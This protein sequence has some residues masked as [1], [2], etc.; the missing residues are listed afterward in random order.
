MSKIVTKNEIR[1]LGVSYFD[2]DLVLGPH[3]QENGRK[4]LQHLLMEALFNYASFLCAI[5]QRGKT[6]FTR[7]SS[8]GVNALYPLIFQLF[9]IAPI[10]TPPKP[11][12]NKR[13]AFLVH[14]R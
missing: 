9:S 2:L 10:L 14:A 3:P 13:L 7:Q 11:D 12:I 5:P 1:S 6:I 4:T 8:Y